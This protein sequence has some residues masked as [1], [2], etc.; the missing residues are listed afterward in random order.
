MHGALAN[1]VVALDQSWYHSLI[2]KLARLGITTL[3]HSTK[4][5]QCDYACDGITRLANH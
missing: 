2:A 4:C 1:A 3:A 5:N